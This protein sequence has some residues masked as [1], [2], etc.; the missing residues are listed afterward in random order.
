MLIAVGRLPEEEH[1]VVPTVQ[2]QGVPDE[3]AGVEVGAAPSG[4]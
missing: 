1:E 4:P 3:L 2:R